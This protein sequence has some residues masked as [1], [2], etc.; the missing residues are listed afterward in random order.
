MLRLHPEV[1]M[2]WK[3]IHYFDS[4]DRDTDSGYA[5]QSR[6]FRAR[7]GWR[8]IAWRLA[9]RS[10]PGARALARR[11]LPLQ[12]TE[13][14]G[15]R[16]S[17]RFLLG[18]ASLDWYRGLFREGA[19]RGLCC[20]EVT[21]AYCMLS[22]PAIARLARD[23][24]EVRAFLIL[25]NPLDWAW[26]GLCKD[27]RD[28]GLDPGK[29]PEAELIARCPVPRPR[30]RADFGGNLGRWLEHFPADRLMVLFHDDIE[31]AP[32]EFLE[33]L[34]AF[35]GVA[36][37]PDRVRGFAEARINS[38]ARDLPMPAAVARHAAALFEPQA[39]IMARLA[40]GPAAGWLERIRNVAR[41]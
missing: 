6:A 20:G 39:E 12:A 34:C 36:A 15:Y 23:L 33:R 14:P 29:L 30:T 4:A 25:R 7:L 19:A 8:Y 21:P 3:E 22:G 9:L 41:G 5:M 16:W 38:S 13:A 35:I 17:A 37:V 26:S 18:E 31:A 32:V 40:G 24:P 27:A 1:W 2:P 28:A 10:L 11:Y